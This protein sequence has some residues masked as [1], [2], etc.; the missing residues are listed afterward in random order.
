MTAAAGV[1]YLSRIPVHGS[2]AANV[3]PGLVVMALGLGLVFVGVQNAANANVPQD[4][5]G[6][7]A[8][9]ITASTTLGGALVRMEIEVPASMAD[10]RRARPD[11]T[12]AD[13][14]LGQ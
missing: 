9:L 14:I 8:A 6:L 4:K 1:W 3:L 5:A 10:R 11:V 7:A 2:Y 12:W 13:A